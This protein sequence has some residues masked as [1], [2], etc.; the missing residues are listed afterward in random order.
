MLPL[1]RTDLEDI[2][3]YLS[4]RNKSSALALFEALANKLRALES[5]PELG[6]PRVGK[7]GLY[8]ILVSGK[9]NILYRY[10][11]GVVTVLRIVHGARNPKSIDDL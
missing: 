1:A 6:A 3:D 4:V 7:I 10:S 11:E 8:R 9:Y 5:L 2:W